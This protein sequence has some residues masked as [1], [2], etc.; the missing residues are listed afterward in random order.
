M[1][2]HQLDQRFSAQLREAT[3]HMHDT[4]STTSGAAT[5]L[6]GRMSRE[7]YIK[8]LSGMWHVYGKESISSD[9]ANFLSC[10]ST[11]PSE[12]QK[13][14]LYAQSFLPIPGPI[15]EYIAHITALS[16]SQDPSLL[17]AHSYIRYVGDLNGG[18]I[19]KRVLVKTF[20]LPDDRAMSFYAF[21]KLGG[22]SGEMVASMGDVAKLL[23]WFKDAMDEGVGNNMELRQRLVDETLI[24]YRFNGDILDLIPPAA[25]V[26][27]SE[28]PSDTMSNLVAKLGKAC[29]PILGLSAAV[30][31]SHLAMIPGTKPI[32]AQTAGCVFMNTTKWMTAV[33]RSTM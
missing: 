17:L 28:A 21:A 14:P 24:A 31:L 26:E 27:T 2:S 16:Q 6:S 18:Q 29:L 1:D 7:E 5:L 32:E 25:S 30:V 4:L 19:I 3:K 11:S 9:I 20:D 8:Y 22:A 12:W 10:S 33:V 23:R 13:H 15:A